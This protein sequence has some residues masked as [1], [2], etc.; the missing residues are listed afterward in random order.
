MVEFVGRDPCNHE[1]N[2]L[3]IILTANEKSFIT[4][5]FLYLTFF[6]LLLFVQLI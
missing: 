2:A 4:D 5:I 3:T 1:L 6:V